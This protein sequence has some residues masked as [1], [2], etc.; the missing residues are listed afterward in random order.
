MRRPSRTTRDLPLPNTAR[1]Q[2]AENPPEL[3]L[4]L[5]SHGI[6]PTMDYSA[7]PI[8][9]A[10]VHPL[11]WPVLLMNLLAVTV[12]LRANG[13]TGASLRVWPNGR[14]E[15][16]RL[17]ET[18]DVSSGPDAQLQGLLALTGRHQQ[19]ASA[20]LL[21]NSAPVDGLG[22]QGRSLSAEA[23]ASV[24]KRAFTGSQAVIGA[25]TS[26]LDQIL[27][28]VQAACQPR[29]AAPTLCAGQPLRTLHPP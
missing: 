25:L 16:T 21:A 13:I 20:A 5:R 14:V 23:P 19:T 27:R 3:I 11:H 22:A 18:H 7:L 15:I 10:R 17:N 24:L 26:V 8:A 1:Q 2:T 6:L 12:Y 29:L 9:L 28:T 4:T